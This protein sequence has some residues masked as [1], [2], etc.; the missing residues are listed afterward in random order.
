[1]YRQKTLDIGSCAT[2]TNFGTPVRAER[3][4]L[5]YNKE[6]EESG[7]SMK[8]RNGQF[9]NKLIQWTYEKPEFNKRMLELKKSMDVLESRLKRPPGKNGKRGSS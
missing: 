2:G 1:M 7:L 6:K 5:T 4:L 8:R 9:Q 3:R